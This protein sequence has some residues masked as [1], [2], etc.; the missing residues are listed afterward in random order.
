MNVSIIIP[1]Y[2]KEN[3]IEETIKSILKQS[4]HGFEI[5]IIDDGSTDNSSHIV[6]SFK[7]DRIK[8]F[9]K[10]N[11]GVSIAR[12][13]GLS[14]A[15]YEWIMYLDADDCLNEFA[16]ENLIRAS[17]KFEN[18]V[19]SCGNYMI[20]FENGNTKKMVKL[21]SEQVISNPSK[22][23][24]LDVWD[25]RLGSFIVRKNIAITKNFPLN[26]TLGEDVLYVNQLLNYKIVYTDYNM[27][28]YNKEYSNL[29]NLKP[30]IEKCY[31]WNNEI[32][33][34]NIYKTLSNL[35]DLGLALFSH[36]RTFQISNFTKLFLKQIVYTPLVI[37]SIFI[38]LL[39][40][41]LCQLK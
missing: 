12:N 17:L 25:M 40:I 24:W 6:K 18:V 27:M 29:S 19:I 26:I 34:K 36:L 30:N 22:L 11:E 33:N 5:V 37:L 15:N 14:K 10:K 32:L 1:L 13:F 16:L 28:I 31:S 39:T 41:F 3:C 2:N 4:Y 21:T 23:Q 38:K 9:Y 20:K 35:Y 7:D 8:Y